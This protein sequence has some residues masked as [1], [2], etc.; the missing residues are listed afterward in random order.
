MKSLKISAAALATV[1]ALMSP[2]AVFAAPAPAIQTYA[3]TLDAWKFGGSAWQYPGQL[4]LHIQPDGTISGW[5][6]NDASPFLT[7]VVGGK[8]GQHIWL[9]IGDTGRLHVNA[10]LQNG[11][12]V[13]TAVE[14]AQL[15]DFTGN[16][17]S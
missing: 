15:Y 13:G 12:L 16:P 8:D 17:V 7:P 6:S 1:F 10:D 14:G 3:T 9:D 11:K 2:F 4:K 5:F